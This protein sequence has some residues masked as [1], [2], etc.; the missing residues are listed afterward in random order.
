[1]ANTEA[2]DY[3]ENTFAEK[4]WAW[5][6]EA[7]RDEDG[8]ATPPGVLRGFIET[9]A[10]QAAVLRRSQDKLWDD[11]FIEL[12]SEWAV[13]YIGE[14]VGTRMVSALNRRGRRIDVAK[15]IYYRQRAGTPRV[16]EELAADIAGWEGKLVEEFRRLG[17]TRH[18]LDPK[19]ADF[20]GRFTRTPPGGWA[21]LRNSR[22]AELVS[23]PFEEF[24]HTPDLRRP[25]GRDGR[26]GIPKLGFHLY[27]LASTPLDGVQPRAWPTAGRFSFDPSG[28]D[29]PLFIRRH[30]TDDREIAADRAKQWEDWQTAQEWQ[31]PAPM[32]CRVLNHAEY[33]I[34]SAA[35]LQL[36]PLLI[37]PGGLSSAAAAA[38][39]AELG[40]FRDYRFPTEAQLRTVTGMIAPSHAAALQ[41]E[42]VWE[43]FLRFT[44]VADCGKRALL[45]DGGASTDT[46]DASVY[47][48][49][50]G[51]IPTRE[52]VVAGNL[53]A[54]TVSVTQRDWVIDP[55]R[56]RLLWVGT[57][58]PPAPLVGYYY[59]FSGPI[60]AG[61]YDRSDAIVSAATAVV[62][63]GGAISAVDPASGVME[64]S[65]SR[66]YT[67]VGGAANL[68]QFEF[69]AADRQRPYLALDADWTLDTGANLE[70]T[71]LLEGL[72]IGAQ[73]AD[74]SVRLS[75]DYETVTLRHVTLDPGGTDAGGATL[76]VV[77]LTVAGNVGRLV[78]ENSIVGPIRILAGGT[79]EEIAISDSI[80]DASNVTGNVAIIAA[81][82]RLSLER[83]TVFG[84]LDVEW[85]YASEA[86]I[87]GYT[88]VTNTQEGC[89]RFSAVVDRQ[90][91]TQPISATNLATRVPRPFESQLLL[92]FT[93]FFTSTVF[94]Q[95]GYAQ[96]GETAPDTVARGA[97]NGSEMGAFSN[98]LNPILADSLGAKVG[99]FAPFGV[100]PFFVF[101]T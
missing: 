75:G 74:R 46:S 68:T 47:V 11:Q 59:G 84:G 10:A 82:G 32:S 2:R 17:R 58:T 96:L 5:V 94:G 30:R 39:V 85:L 6:P 12:C 13:P 89:F 79:V 35:L 4:L 76:P 20:A 49:V 14:L 40:R 25:R 42:A 27:R 36:Q 83:V 37:S 44:L 15:T 86:I 31:L 1:M 90:N 88:D 22:G 98:L 33:V 19:P 69:R 66:T 95:P 45:P 8:T 21:D 72:W 67:P 65:D 51:A 80:V 26:Y 24:H 93:G 63:G 23:G 99:E 54:W 92:T 55:A 64:I 7:F 18:G 16:L 70:S 57:G 56:G 53:A 28:R 3:F 97:E 52:N 50:G 81:A 78:I 34:T 61:G 62:S 101:E 71:L 43:S 73:G 77:T 38:T 60:G 100:L 91:P 87:T 41:V 9:L 29:I 48:N